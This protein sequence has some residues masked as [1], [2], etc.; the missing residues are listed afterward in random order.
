MIRHW[1][2]PAPLPIMQK[3]RNDPVVG[4]RHDAAAEPLASAPHG[5]PD[6]PRTGSEGVGEMGNE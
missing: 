2:I 6:G 1:H 5:R 3:R 4:K